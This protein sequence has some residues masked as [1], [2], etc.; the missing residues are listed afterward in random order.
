[1]I[2]ATA[3][4]ILQARPF[5]I[6][7]ETEARW[8]TPYLKPFVA[9]LDEFERHIIVVTD[10][11]HGRILS[12]F[13]GAVELN[14][15]VR[16]LEETTHIQTTGMDHLESQSHFQRRADENT[17]RHLRHLIVELESV[18]KQ[19]PA[20]RIVV[21]GNVEA[22]AQLLKLLPKAVNDKVAGTARVSVNDRIEDMVE[23][24]LKVGG[25]VEREDEVEDV[26]RL[27]V[28]A[29]KGDKAT[30][31]VCDTLRALQDGRVHTLYYAHK[32]GIPGRQCSGCLALFPAEAPEDCG[33]CGRATTSLTDIMDNILRKAVESSS[34]IEEV[35][36]P[37]ADKLRRDGGLAAMLRY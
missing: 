3:N 9:A 28:A 1:V 22:V 13:L 36:G 6:D 27:H 20:K 37:G 10:K 25:Q 11:W 26:D 18:L 21:G 8:G 2:F 15:E 5:N 16:D 34:E 30:T 24:A 23:I 32:T 33:F 14:T 7:L 19:H 31:G 17:R 12:V 29:A 35:R 4:G